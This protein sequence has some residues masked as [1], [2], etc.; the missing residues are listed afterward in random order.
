MQGS[1]RPVFLSFARLRFPVGAVASIGHRISGVVLACALP[2]AA[3][4]LGRS[5][6][7]E[8]DY[9]SVVDGLQSPAGRVALIVV[10]WAAGHYLLA[11]IRHLL[12]DIGVGASLPAARASAFAVI[13]L[14][15]LAAALPLAA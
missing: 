3:V 11:G 1:R 7:E 13:A 12:M 9:A 10:A 2:F 15:V 6:S 14:A 8:G 5:F 4:A